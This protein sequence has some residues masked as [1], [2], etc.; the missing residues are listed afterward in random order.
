MALADWLLGRS[1]ATDEEGEQ[2]VGVA[3]GIPMLGL[4]ALGSAAYGPEAALT[5]LIP[6]GTAGLAYV[7]P[8]TT[9]II[10][11]LVIVYFSYRQ[12]ITAY[13][14][15]GGSYSRRKTWGR[16]PGFARQPSCSTTSGRGGRHLGGVGLDL[17]GSCLA[18]HTLPSASSSSP[19]HAR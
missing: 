8:I 7:G 4:D 5:L 9:L 16:R 1:L 18:T 12:T 17:R 10:V 13:P 6:L 2:R 11:L 15:G 19:H 14:H 3:A